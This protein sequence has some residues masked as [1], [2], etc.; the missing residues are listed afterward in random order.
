MNRVLALLKTDL[1]QVGRFDHPA[2]H[3]HRD[4]PEELASGYSVS[5]VEHGEFTMAGEKGRGYPRSG[6]VILMYPGMRFRCAHPAAHPDDVCLCVSFLDTASAEQVIPS[7]ATLARRKSFHFIRSASNRLAYLQL[8]LSRLLTRNA[9]PAAV[10][11]LAGEILRAGFEQQDSA[12]ARQYSRRQ[13]AWY[14]DRIEVAR[15]FLDRECDLQHSLSSLA[16]RVNMSPFHFARVFRTLVGKPPHRYLLER[17]LQ[18]AAELL[19][20]G[21]SVTEACFQGRKVH[22]RPSDCES[23]GSC[24]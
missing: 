8:R 14:M 24:G 6:S 15:Q 16:A 23:R 1:I 3:E 10:E 4:P 5:F 22:G 7:I 11:A 13:L 9:E 17:R 12:D 21:L 18:R 2:D 19:R 20:G